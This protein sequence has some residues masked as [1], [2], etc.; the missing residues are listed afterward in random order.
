MALWLTVMEKEPRLE[1]SR[2]PQDPGIGSFRLFSGEVISVPRAST[3]AR[4]AFQGWTP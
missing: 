2:A 3:T 1:R 4:E